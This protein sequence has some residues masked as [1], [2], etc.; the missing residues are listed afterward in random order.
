[1]P[2]TDSDKYIVGKHPSHIQIVLG[3][4]MGDIY[5]PVKAFGWD[6]ATEQTPNVHSGSPLPSDLIDGHHAY[7]IN[8][9]TSTWLT[10][11]VDK[12]TADKWEYLTFTHLVRPYD[13]GRSKEF[14]VM[15][16]QAEYYDDNDEAV[17]AGTITWFKR[18]KI[19]HMAYQQGENGIV[20]RTF[21]AGAMRMV[22]G[23]SDEER[24]GQA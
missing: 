11:G 17:G 13:H 19:N 9:E 20:K 16:K 10:L 4:K 8:F 1:M 21:E 18:C 22:Y 24:G 2:F 12:E 14:N 3:T 23:T 6:K 15:I 5:L 7:K